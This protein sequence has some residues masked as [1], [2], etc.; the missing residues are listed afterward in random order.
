ML[1]RLFRWTT[2][3][4]AL[5]LLGTGLVPKGLAARAESSA[6]PPDLAAGYRFT[7]FLPLPS[8]PIQAVYDP[9]TQAALTEDEAGTLTLFTETA[10]AWV[11]TGSWSLDNPGNLG[12][13][14]AVAPK[15]GT[16]VVLNPATGA[17]WRL[18][19]APSPTQD[20]LSLLATDPNTPLYLTVGPRSNTCYAVDAAS[21]SWVSLFAPADTLPDRIALPDPPSGPAGVLAVGDDTVLFIP[22]ATANTPAVMR[23]TVNPSSGTASVAVLPDET[24]I[25]VGVAVDGQG[26]LWVEE[27]S[28]VNQPGGVQYVPD[29]VYAPAITGP[30]LLPPAGDATTSL[31]GSLALGADGLYVLGQ[32]A[33]GSPVLMVYRPNPGGLTALGGP[34][35]QGPLSA[36]GGVVLAPTG[37]RLLWADFGEGPATLPLN[38]L[39]LPPLNS[40]S[41][42]LQATQ[43]ALYIPAASGIDRLPT[44]QPAVPSTFPVSP[45]PT[46]GLARLP[47]GALAVA[48]ANPPAIAVYTPTGTLTATAATYGGAVATALAPWQGGVAALEGGNLVA[49][50]GGTATPLPFSGAA[51]L[52]TAG[53]G[54]VAIGGGQLVG[55][56][57]QGAPWLSAQAS[58]LAGPAAVTPDGG[59]LLATD[60]NASALTVVS[61]TQGLLGTVPLDPVTLGAGQSTGPVESLALSPHG[62][63][64]YALTPNGVA[65]FKGPSLSLSAQTPTAPVGAAV[66]LTATLQDATGTPQAGVPVVFGALGT[67]VTDALGTAS[68]TVSNSTPGPVTYLAQAPGVTAEATVTW[69][70]S[71]PPAPPPAPAPAPGPKAPPGAGFSGWIVRATP[72]PSAG[73]HPPLLS[74]AAAATLP[75]PLPVGHLRWAF[76]VRAAGA[77]RDYPARYRLTIAAPPGFVHPFSLWVYSAPARRWFPLFPTRVAPGRMVARTPAL[78]CFAISD[79][80]PPFAFSLDGDRVHRAAEIAVMTFPAG[81]QSAV[82]AAAGPSGHTPPDAVAAAPLARRLD[83]PLLLTPS[84][85]LAA[86]DR[87]A[88]VA[89]GVRRVFVVGGP[90]AIAPAVVHWLTTHGYT[91][92][93]PFQGQDRAATAL[94]IATAVSD[95]PG[96]LSPHAVYLL[97]GARP[98]DGA[99]VAELAYTPAEGPILY[100]DP[101]G[102]DTPA[103][104]RW[105]RRHPWIIPVEVGPPA[106]FAGLRL[107]PDLVRRLKTLRASD[108]GQLADR[109]APQLSDPGALWAPGPTGHPGVEA[110]LA[111]VLGRWY[112]APLAFPGTGSA[113]PP[114]LWHIL[115]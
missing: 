32:N 33:Q 11:P 9:L 78:T 20:T 30:T 58:G 42:E 70:A 110:V 66:T 109:L 36:N 104:V 39:A 13:D 98:G 67:A 96:S 103:L 19:L 57:P 34:A 81:A 52:L 56:R 41:A 108:P 105:L 15:G 89:L 18:T 62:R 40:F 55:L 49:W 45:Q 114:T 61:V 10:S 97:D 77:L 3:V 75:R 69:V 106:D 60:P 94:D 25:P 86:A 73:P 35:P 51:S 8:A 107:P 101:H 100:W 26:G 113:R 92:L 47:N 29:A 90:A 46:G 5:L 12:P 44:I 83:A 28:T 112:R 63:W 99:P 85:H 111:G 24:G 88:L 48:V 14:L 43:D 27:A 7:R 91:V 17:I 87:Q 93:T 65:A 54:V 84:D 68:I 31:P 80:P 50:P 79:A 16:A 64:L 74:V 6:V 21:L 82:L 4:L 76:V 95:W 59:Y 38:D 115:L 22:S 2:V 23:V 71:G 53:P 1:R 102:N 72:G 37:H